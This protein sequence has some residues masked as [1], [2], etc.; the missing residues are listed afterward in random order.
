MGTALRHQ[1]VAQAEQ[2]SRHRAKGLALFPSWLIKLLNQEAN[3]NRFLVDIQPGAAFIDNLHTV[4]PSVSKGRPY[5]QDSWTGHGIPNGVKFSPT[6]F[7]KREQ[8][9]LVRAGIQVILLVRLVALVSNRPSALDLPCLLVYPFSWA[10]V[11]AS[12]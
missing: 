2:I 11:R 7:P 10:L 8:Q 9:A 4:S 3:G 6:C 1:P 5:H 12:A